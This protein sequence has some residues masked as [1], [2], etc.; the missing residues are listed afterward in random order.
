MC[1]HAYMPIRRAGSIL[2]LMQASPEKDANAP[3]G[4]NELYLMVIMRA[5]RE[6]EAGNTHSGAQEVFQ[7]F[8]AAGLWTQRAD[9]LQVNTM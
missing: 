2:G 6:V 7:D 5:V 8:H 3:L 9:D 1:K 4:H